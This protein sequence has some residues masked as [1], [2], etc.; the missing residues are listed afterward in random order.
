MKITI[1]ILAVILI[2]T[3]MQVAAQIQPQP[4]PVKRSQEK[5]IIH[6]Q[7]FYIHTVQKGQTLYSISKAYEVSQ[8]EILREN[9]G[10]DSTALKEGQAI[11]IPAEASK[12]AASYP[13]DKEAFREH[14]VRRGQTVYSLSKKYDVD[15]ELIYQ[16]NPWA[17]EGIEPDQTIWIPR[18]R[19]KEVITSGEEQPGYYYHTVKEKETLYSISLIYGVPVSV[20][21]D[22]NEFLRQGLKPRQLIRIPKLLANPAETGIPEDEAGKVE[23]CLPAG[24]ENVTYN[25]ALLLPFFAQ[26]N[27]EELAIPVDTVSEEGTYVPTQK[28]QSFRGRN[29]AEFYEGFLLAVDSLKSTGLSLNLQ[30]YDTERDTM[31]VK[32]IMRD[33]SSV[34]SDLIIGPVYTEDVNIAGRLARYKEVNLISPLSNRSGLVSQNSRIFQVI[35]SRQEESKCMADYIS[36]F[37]KGSI[38]LIRGTDSIS[39]RDSWLFKKNLLENLPADSLGRPLAF[40]D[41]QLNDSLMTKLDKV[42]SQHD[43]NIIIIFSESEPDVSRLVSNLYR[44]SS[45][46]PVM[47]FGL[48]EWQSWKTIEL[49]YFHSL[50]LH[51]ISP[52]YVD[53]NNPKIDHFLN[54]CRIVYGYEPYETTSRG[55]NFC[56]LGYDL[57]IYFLSALKQYGKDFQQCLSN[58]DTDVL[59]SK[60]KFVQDGEGG[61]VNTGFNLIQYNPDF[62]I[63]NSFLGSDE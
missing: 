39:L 51:L 59:L 18:V 31:K 61:F 58:M 12:P 8:D 33:L 29:F 22:N 43:E 21:V 32:K 19:E 20:I 50:N 14:R 56:M 13:Q 52:F 37:K 7:I 35:P 9:S 28:L 34:Q 15:E 6:G 40:H 25:V 5:T 2:T 45:L 42:L 48:P 60:Y 46:Y 53:Y 3:C 47:L 23:P 38:V 62:T 55:Y 36:G 27:T 54:K 1:S 44:M 17:R 41:Y 11:R 49:N 10:L 26:Y 63:T 57:G 16:Y 24:T 30:V 4:V